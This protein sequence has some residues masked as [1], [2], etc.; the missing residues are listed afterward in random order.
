MAPDDEWIEA[1]VHLN[2]QSGR[3]ERRVEHRQNFIVQVL[4]RWLVDDDVQILQQS[5]TGLNGLG[6]AEDLPAEES[7]Q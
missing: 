7:S 1:T 6:H 2:L 3:L 5:D 4:G